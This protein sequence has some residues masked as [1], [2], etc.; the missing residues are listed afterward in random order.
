MWLR[1]TVVSELWLLSYTTQSGV[2]TKS[3]YAIIAETFK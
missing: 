2:Q 3:F 1:F